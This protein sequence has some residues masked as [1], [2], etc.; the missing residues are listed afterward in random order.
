[1]TDR[2]ALDGI[3]VIELSQVAAGP[4]MASFLGDMGADVVKVEPLEGDSLRGIDDA[5]GPRSSSYFFGVN[6][7]KR[8]IAVDLRSAAGREIIG[9]LVRT[10]DVLIVSMRPSAIERAGLGYAAL[11]GVAPRLV[12][13]SVTG[14]GDDG[15]R[16]EQP[17]MDILAQALS[18]LMG[19]TGEAGRPP[20]KVGPPVADVTTSYLGCFAVCAALLA[21]ERDG[22]GQKISLNLLDSAV[23]LMP[24]FGAQYLRLRR[25]IRPM[26]GAH[27]QIVPYQVFP[28]A[29]GY[30]VVACISERFWPRMCEAIEHPEL[31]ADPR[32]RTNPDRVLNRDAL[33]PQLAD[34]FAAR[35]TDA[36]LAVLERSDVPCSAVHWIE[37][38]VTDPQVI[39]NGMVIRLEHPEVG[40]YETLGNP[41]KM[42]ASNPRPRGWA[43]GLGEHTREVLTELGYEPAEIAALATA[44]AVLLAD[45]PG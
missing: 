24:N 20:V 16:A 5:Y 34:I 6:R 30:M 2:P 44:K 40:R 22:R 27:P 36:W 10:A 26:G 23:S 32:F 45:P 39:H 4:L 9:R 19:L 13:V 43:P 35:P 12:Y 38:V 42:S 17:G 15:P 18:G 3:R 14:Y 33:I 37:D 8:G 25:P 1:M 11:S 7:S 31:I 41:V 28:T 29:D 21:R